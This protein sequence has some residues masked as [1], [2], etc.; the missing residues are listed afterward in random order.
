M[1]AVLWACAW[2]AVPDS[3]ESLVV[4]PRLVVG[5]DVAADVSVIDAQSRTARG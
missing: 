5:E 1:L 4:A 3:Y 2:M